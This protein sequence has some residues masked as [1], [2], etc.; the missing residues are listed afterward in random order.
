MATAPIREGELHY[1]VQGSGP[2][3]VLVSGLGGLGSFWH[4]QVPA[5]AE[6]FSVVTF[7]H[8]GSGRSSK[9]PPP[10]SIDGMVEDVL[11]LLGR[12]GRGKVRYVGHSTG[13]AIG[14]RLAARHPERLAALVLSATWTHPDAYFQR[15]FRL[16]RDV[17]RTAGGELYGRLATLLVY[18]SEWI[19]RHSTELEVPEA[20]PW[21]PLDVEI[22]A[23]KIEALL[24]FDA[25]SDLVAIRSPTLVLAAEDD[26]T[27]P[28]YFAPSLQEH[29][30]GARLHLLRSGGHY[31][32][33]TRAEEYNAALLRFLETVAE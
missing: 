12:L 7:D 6:R 13:G 27:V 9:S 23:A 18:P 15:L 33:I 14:Q 10:Y 5:L 20:R 16:R 29:I 1:E 4:R 2:T 26:V 31:C 25:R 8:R 11:A 30:P 17:L 3:V 19:A 21:S 22:L 28:S 32:P 24:S